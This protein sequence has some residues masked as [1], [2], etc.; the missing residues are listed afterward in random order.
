MDLTP[1]IPL[2]TAVVTVPLSSWLTALLLRKKYDTE[3]EQLRAQVAALKTDTKGDELKNVREGMS[4]L[5]EEVVEPIKKE[6]NAVRRELARFRKAVEKGATC[7]HYG[8]CP[9]VNELRLTESTPVNK[10]SSDGLDHGGRDP[11]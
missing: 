6:I 2:I 5:M 4:I 11:T 3:V 10:Q 8:M 7:K 1:Y 9:I